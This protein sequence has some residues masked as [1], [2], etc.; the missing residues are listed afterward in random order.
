[1]DM[2]AGAERMLKYGMSMPD[3]LL[4]IKKLLGFKRDSI[5]RISDTIQSR[6]S[7]VPA[8][9][10]PEPS[11]NTDQPTT[12]N[13]LTAQRARRRTHTRQTERDKRGRTEK[14]TNQEKGLSVYLPRVL[15]RNG[16]IVV[17]QSS[18]RT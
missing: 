3:E 2:I 17:V 10:H 16:I 11:P 6:T 7:R 18:L 8:G 5:D 14:T 15:S 9:A 12:S 4:V 1:M 13:K